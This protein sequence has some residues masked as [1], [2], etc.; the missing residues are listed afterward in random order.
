MENIKELLRRLDNISL[1]K[2]EK[3]KIECKPTLTMPQAQQLLD[4]IKDKKD[5]P[6]LVDTLIFELEYRLKE[7]KLITICIEFKEIDLYWKEM[8]EC[9]WSQEFD[10]YLKWNYRDQCPTALDSYIQTEIE[11]RRE[12]IV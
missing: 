12:I 5:L 1:S 3:I 4:Y 7:L 6:D 2:L 9:Y 8:K 11:E 10:W